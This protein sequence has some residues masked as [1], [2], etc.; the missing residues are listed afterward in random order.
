MF[1]KD[2]IEKY[3]IQLSRIHTAVR[4]A[5]ETLKETQR[6]ITGV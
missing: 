6:I 1:E 3:D 4:N 5:D 2:I